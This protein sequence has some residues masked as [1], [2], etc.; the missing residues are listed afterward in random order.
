[1]PFFNSKRINIYRKAIKSFSVILLLVLYLGGMV[2]V[3]VLHRLLHAHKDISKHLVEDEEDPCHRKIFHDD[4]V[5]GCEHNTHVT[6]TAKCQ[7]C[8][9]FVSP[10]HIALS[11]PAVKALTLSDTYYYATEISTA[12]FLSF[13]RPSRAPPALA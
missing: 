2:E 8:Q 12:T 3:S 6:S 7:E 1:M 11:I 5:N 4:N 10:V 9:Q 13:P